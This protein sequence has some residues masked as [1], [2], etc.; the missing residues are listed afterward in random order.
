MTIGGNV[1][2]KCLGKGFDEDNKRFH[3][4]GACDRI[5]NGKCLA[6]IYPGL[7]WREGLFS[8]CPLAT[9]YDETIVVK[10]KKR[11]GQQKQKKRG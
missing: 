11:V 8:A 7:K 2:D 6:Y 3:K 10:T 9:H 5:E 1:I 4:G